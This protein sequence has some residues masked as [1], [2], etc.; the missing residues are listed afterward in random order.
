[1]RTFICMLFLVFLT[2]T[3]VFAQETVPVEPGLHAKLP[4]GWE[5]APPS[6]GV[7]A[8]FRQS[9]DAKTRV[10]MRVVEVENQE[11]AQR[12]FS[13]YHANLVA[14]GLKVILATTDKSY[15]SLAGRL[16]KYSG[17]VKD[18]SFELAL[19]EFTHKG[20]AWLVIGFATDKR[21][22]PMFAAFEAIAAT[23]TKA[24]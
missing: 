4:S 18:G 20:S 24:P 19:F 15:G 2:A 22:V 1:M 14:T 6:T 8:T 13:S 5:S 17:A 7:A 10:E 21:T 16:T 9:G 23:I 3:P 12:Y 11:Q